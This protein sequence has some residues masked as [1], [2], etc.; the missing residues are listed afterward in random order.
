MNDNVTVFKLHSGEVVVAHTDQALDYMKEYLFITMIHPIQILSR[1]SLVSNKETYFLK[2]WIAM[3]DDKIL[4]VNVEHITTATPLKKHLEEGYNNS[5]R[6]F[7]Y[8]DSEVFEEYGE[9]FDDSEFSS[10]DLEEYADAIINKKI[11]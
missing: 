4:N 7:Y 2:P 10:Q 8:A 6:M 11:N 9:S 1:D 5:V 3:G